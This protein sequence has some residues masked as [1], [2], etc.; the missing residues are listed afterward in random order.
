MW[1]DAQLACDGLDVGWC[2]S[3]CVAKGWVGIGS[4]GF[5]DG[6]CG[7]VSGWSWCG[8]CGCVVAGVVWMVVARGNA[9][10][11][12]RVVL[13]GWVAWVACVVDVVVLVGVV[14]LV[15]PAWRAW[16]V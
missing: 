1:V 9:C 16:S 2:G 5:G 6:S 3:L 13:A 4:N 11:L 8:W 15:W 12:R 14:G 7:F 10:N